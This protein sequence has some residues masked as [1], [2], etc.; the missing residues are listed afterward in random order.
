MGKLRRS[1]ACAAIAA[2]VSLLAAAAAQANTVTLGSQFQGTM[3]SS[4]LDGGKGT[5]VNTSLPAP[6]IVG[7]PSDGTV[8]DWRFSGGTTQWTPQILRP[9]GNGTYTEAAQGPAQQ[10][11][12]V[13]TI[14]GPFPLNIPVKKGDLIGVIGTNFS[15]LGVIDSASAVYGYWVPPLSPGA[16]RAPDFGG[17]GVEDAISATLRYCLVPSL[18]GKKPKAAKKALA[19]ANCVFGGKSKSKKRRE[20][21]KVVGQS[22]AAGTSISDTAPVAIKVSRPKR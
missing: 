21:K 9:L 17:P 10:G 22:V 13:G 11:A 15:N 2:T 18:K 7:A 1:A 8:L 12:G 4:V 14:S 19:A 3:Q 16:G 20:K 6:L 5:V